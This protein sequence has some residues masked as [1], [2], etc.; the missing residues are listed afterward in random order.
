MSIFDDLEA[1][2]DEIAKHYERLEMEARRRGWKKKEKI[3]QQRRMIN[4]QAY[5][6]FMFTRLEER[7]RQESSKLIGKKKTSTLSWRNKAP[8]NL[9]SHK[10]DD[11]RI[12]FMSRVT[13]LTPKGGRDYN[14]LSDYYD[15]RNSIAHGGSFTCALNMAMVTNEI[16]RLHKALK[17]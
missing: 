2:Y 12:S 3:Y 5:F 1:Q 16:K 17:A 13:L 10:P 4:D 14:I 11:D 15:E 9:L 6:L 8:W 7:I